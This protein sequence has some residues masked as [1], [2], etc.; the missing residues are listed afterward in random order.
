MTT[1]FTVTDSTSFTITH[2]R[3][4]A[5]K[6]ATDLKRMQRFYGVP[7][8]AKIEA[9]QQELILLVKEGYLE[10]VTYG[11][12]RDGNWIQPTLRYTARDLAGSIAD[13]DD[14]GRVLPGA[15]TSGA[16]FYSFLTHSRAW[17]ECSA[18]KKESFKTGLPFQRGDGSEPGI[19]GYLSC[20]RMYSAG[21][22]S[23]ERSSVKAF[24]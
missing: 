1:S 13:D 2:A 3:H 18:A 8:D 5:T 11:F 19:S 7:T 16:S 20:D 22:R 21:G 15:D 12:K 24:G 4:L 23:L 14:P 6:V 10:T 9:Y 17:D